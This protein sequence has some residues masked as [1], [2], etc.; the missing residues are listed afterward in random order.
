MHDMPNYFGMNTEH[1]NSHIRTAVDALCRQLEDN[2]AVPD[3]VQ[4][5]ARHLQ[6]AAVHFTNTLYGKG[7]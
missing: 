6:Q 5:S 3:V 4:E 1:L 2:P 7:A